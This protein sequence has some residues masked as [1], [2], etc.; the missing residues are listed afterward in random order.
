MLPP[1]FLDIGRATLLIRKFKG[2]SIKVLELL[3]KSMQEESQSA[4]CDMIAKFKMIRNFEEKKYV[5]ELK[6][7]EI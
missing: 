4:I 5:K 6:E 7:F 2:M 1:D 3:T